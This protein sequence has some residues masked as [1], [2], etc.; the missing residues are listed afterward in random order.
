MR[1]VRNR[2]ARLRAQ[3]EAAIPAQRLS[4]Q[5][6]RQQRRRRRPRTRWPAGGYP[7]SA[8]RF[9]R[10]MPGCRAMLLVVVAVVTAV[11]EAVAITGGVTRAPAEA[12]GGRT[13]AGEVRCM[14]G[15]PRRTATPVSFIF[16]AIG[17]VGFVA[18]VVVVVFL[19]LLLVSLLLLLLLLLLLFPSWSLS[20]SSSPSSP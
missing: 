14:T 8:P 13:R 18:A 1:E 19:L 2:G 17:G 15:I 12:L 7:P 6:P 9:R 11:V 5:Q 3:L 20:S 10:T 16:L 4:P